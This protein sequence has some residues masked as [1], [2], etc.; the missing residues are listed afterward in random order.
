M[1]TD[2]GRAQKQKTLFLPN[3]TISSLLVKSTEKG[4]AISKD[5]FWV[6]I[7]KD[8]MLEQ[9]QKKKRDQRKTSQRK[10]DSA[11]RNFH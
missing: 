10:M 9:T 2:S 3:G 1:P 7:S 6:H 4:N 8:R 11:V 5:I